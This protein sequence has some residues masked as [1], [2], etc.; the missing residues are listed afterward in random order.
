MKKTKTNQLHSLY[1]K[2][3]KKKRNEIGFSD[4][5]LSSVC[6]CESKATKKNR[7]YFFSISV[8]H[9]LHTLLFKLNRMHAE[10][11]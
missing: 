4:L 2:S 8:I 1:S 7:R 3:K 11:K 6:V 9:S 5:S 10:E